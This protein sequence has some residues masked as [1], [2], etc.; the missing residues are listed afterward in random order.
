MQRKQGVIL[1][2]VNIFISTIVMI[3][4]TPFVIKMLGQSEFGLYSLALSIMGYIAIFDFG[5]GNAIIVF[6]SKFLIKNQTNKQKILYS[7]V[8]SFYIFMS[9]LVVVFGIIFLNNIDIIFKNSFDAY[10]IKTLKNIILLLIFNMAFLLPCSIFS[11]ILNAYE[12]F[13]FMK[14]MGIL[15]SLLTPII[16]AVVL[17]SGFKSTQ[18]IISITI[19]N[20]LYTFFIILYY[21]K[22]IGIKIDIFNFK[23]KALK[24]ILSY[25]VFV[26]I[27]A[28]VDQINW[29][30]GQ[31][32]VGSALGAKEVGIFAISILFNGMF[33]MLSTAISSVFLPKI[34]Q[35]VSSG[36]SNEILTDEMIK[37]GRLQ[38]Y[39]IFCMLFGFILF[40]QKFIEIWAGKEY[41]DAY[42]LTVII[43]IPLAIP[44]VQNLGISILQ[45]KNKYAFR[46]LSA[47]IG[48]ILS[49]ISSIYFVKIYGYYGVAFSICMSFLMVNG[50]IVNWY[51][52]KIGLNIFKFWKNIFYN[53]FPQL[54]LFILFNL[55][56]EFMNEKLF[57][58]SMIFFII[59]YTLVSYFISMNEYEKSLIKSLIV[60]NKGNI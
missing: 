38:G 29:N 11:S 52:K 36:V 30:F 41:Q 49:I 42:Y 54:V 13:I 45:A 53:F 32:I 56:F 43:M 33:I 1:T 2:Y 31:L 21:R 48:A 20:I 22:N 19:L 5:L 14:K 3:F 15:R 27:A 57:F 4:Y 24:I 9:F 7:T 28:I 8:F 50:V 47:L 18:I 39:I 58:I 17:F 37:I 23:F 26:F 59:S 51:Y 55:F 34:S 44:L 6:T 10:E 25:S 35:M 12:K 46:S 40:G 60:K 16:I